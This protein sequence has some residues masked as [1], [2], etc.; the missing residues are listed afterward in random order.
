MFDEV[1]QPGL[2]DLVENGL[3]VAIKHPV[4]APPTDPERECI[5]RL[6][7][8]TL[9]SEPVAE[10]QELRLV[11]RR[12]DR[13]HRRLDDLIFQCSNADRPLSAICLWNISPAR[14]Q[15]SITLPF[16]RESGGPRFSSRPSA[17]RS[18]SSRRPPAL[19]DNFLSRVLQ[20]S[21]LLSHLR[22]CE[23]YDE[24]ETLPYS[25][26]RPMSA[27]GGQSAPTARAS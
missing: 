24:P 22:S 13:N 3:D 16:G 21:G 18:R 9:R 15:R 8:T 12:Q 23:R 17:F 20:W 10:P 5:Q 4:D 6:V 2:A 19:L 27:D 1:D 11:D 7:L 14:W 25:I 26:R